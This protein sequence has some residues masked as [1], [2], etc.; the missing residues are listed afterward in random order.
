MPPDSYWWINP[1]LASWQNP[2]YSATFRVNSMMLKYKPGLA[3]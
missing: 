3:V 2:S 1:Q